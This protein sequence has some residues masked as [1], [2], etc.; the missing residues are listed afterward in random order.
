MHSVQRE[1]LSDN[2]VIYFHA[3]IK[4]LVILKQ[5]VLSVFCVKIYDI[6][7]DNSV[8]GPLY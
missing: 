5:F 2:F 8:H 3:F 7:N 4:L 1:K 6:T